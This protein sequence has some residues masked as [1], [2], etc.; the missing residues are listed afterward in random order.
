MRNRCERTSSPS[1]KYY[2]ARGIA[3]APEWRRSFETFAVDMGDLP[4]GASIDRID[5]DGNYEPGNCR[6]AQPSE[7]ARNKRQTV[8]VVF[9]GERLALADACDAAGLPYSL[10]IQRL[11]RLGWNPERALSEPARVVRS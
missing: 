1:W 7:Q 10:V 11:R 4:L 5:P 6:W 2:G 9:R 8:R 3:V